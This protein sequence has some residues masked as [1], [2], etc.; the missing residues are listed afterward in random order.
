MWIGPPW[1]RKSNIAFFNLRFC[2]T[3][4]GDTMIQERFHN[5]CFLLIPREKIRK[6]YF[7]IFSGEWKGSNWKKLL[8]KQWGFILCIWYGVQPRHTRSK[9][10]TV[11]TFYYIFNNNNAVCHLYSYS[12]VISIYFGI[13][14]S[15]KQ[16]DEFMSLF[17]ESRS[18][19]NYKTNNNI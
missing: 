4:E 12:S 7:L 10:N 15:W 17:C 16:W 19:N 14:I 11:W 8:D 1:A 3:Y 2:R 6:K 18:N 9:L 13:T 5:P